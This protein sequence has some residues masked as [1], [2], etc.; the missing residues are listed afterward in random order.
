L[1][2]NV[3][4]ITMM[5]GQRDYYNEQKNLISTFNDAK[6]QIFRLNNA[7]ERYAT[8]IR[9]GNLIK[10]DWDLDEVYGE[11]YIDEE[12]EDEGKEEGKQFKSKFKKINDLIAKHK[13]DTSKFYLVLKMKERLLR[14]L[15]DL[16]GKGAKRSSEDEDDIDN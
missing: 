11:L 8:S 4:G 16:S 2:Y 1:D 15:Q 9:S 3:E 13:N 6:L 5:D 12:Y 7:W 10:A 14:R